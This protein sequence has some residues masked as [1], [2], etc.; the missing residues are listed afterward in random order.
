M[1]RHTINPSNKRVCHYNIIIISAS[2]RKITN[3]WTN[4]PLK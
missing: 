2:S 3:I 1:V 4:D